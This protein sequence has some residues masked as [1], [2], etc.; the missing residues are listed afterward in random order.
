MNELDYRRL[1]K[2][3]PERIEPTRDLWP[4]IS[5]RL[6]AVPA[7]RR[8]HALFPFA[9]AASLLCAAVF[10]GY[11]LLDVKS[12]DHALAGNE[13]TMNQMPLLWREREALA[14]ESQA[15][16]QQMGDGDE[17]SLMKRAGPQVY[18]TWIE[19]DGAET[20]LEAALKSAPQS[21]F[22]MTRLKRVELE[23]LK[24]ARLAANV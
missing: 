14:I 19:L 23:K 11:L 12:T 22:L 21:D 4:G 5:K 18:A 10:G 16:W 3:L 20:E 24:L 13:S 9:A 15:A 6:D 1:L 7:R 2:Q 8:F 17:R